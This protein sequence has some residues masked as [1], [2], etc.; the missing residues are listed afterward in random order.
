MP[1]VLTRKTSP[2]YA[3]IEATQPNNRSSIK[4]LHTATMHFLATALVNILV[5]AFSLQ[6]VLASP[7]S[8]TDIERRW[9]AG[10]SDVSPLYPFHPPPPPLHRSTNNQK[11]CRKLTLTNTTRPPSTP[12]TTP[13]PPPPPGPSPRPRASPPRSPKPAR[14]A[15]S[16]G[17]T[18]PSHSR[19]LSAGERGAWSP[20][21]RC[22]LGSVILRRG[23]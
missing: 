20:L 8:F 1:V 18:M 2:L 9:S 11:E 13:A 12:P 21:L 19:A 10:E 23:C 5:L 14:T 16:P 7:L 22:R 17:P 15:L 3:G 4:G 6:V